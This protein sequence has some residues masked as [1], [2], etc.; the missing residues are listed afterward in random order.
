MHYLINTEKLNQMF[1]ILLL[2]VTN[3]FFNNNN[4]NNKTVTIKVKH[5]APVQVILP[6]AVLLKD[7]K[8]LIITSLKNH[9]LIKIS[10]KLMVIFS[11]NSKRLKVTITTLNQTKNFIKTC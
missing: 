1:Q 5:S 4:N 2:K 3:F 9:L 8:A 7:V 11:R 10:E 6:K